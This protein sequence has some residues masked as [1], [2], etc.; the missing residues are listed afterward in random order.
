M[1]ANSEMYNT[2]TQSS[3]R[4]ADEANL[5]HISDCATMRSIH[6]IDKSQEI[7]LVDGRRDGLS[8][9]TNMI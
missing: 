4:Q 5:I 7:R 6:F 3:R 2:M 8:L 9:V 1:K